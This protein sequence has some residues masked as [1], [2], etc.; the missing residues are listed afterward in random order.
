MLV[1]G[2][3]SIKDCELYAKY[4]TYYLNKYAYLIFCLP[5]LT[6][7]HHSAIPSFI[8]DFKT[9][10]GGQIPDVDTVVAEFK[11]IAPG[12]VRTCYNEFFTNSSR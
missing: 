3:S 12:T 11:D 9:K 10:T 1:T 2:F 6:Y 5:A 4:Q 8:E 7:D